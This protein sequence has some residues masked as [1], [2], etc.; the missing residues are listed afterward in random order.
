MPIV[1]C[2]SHPTA[3]G[4]ISSA[5]VTSADCRP[6]RIASTVSGASNVS[7]RTGQPHRNGAIRPQPSSAAAELVRCPPGG[8]ANTS[9][10]EWSARPAA[11]QRGAAS[12]RFSLSAAQRHGRSA[13]RLFIHR[14]IGHSGEDIVD[15]C[16]GIDV[17]VASTE[18]TVRATAALS[19]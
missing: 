14:M 9:N 3:N 17:A 8:G 19:S 15:P 16:L 2:L 4:F 1:L 7:R 13:A 12:W 10:G 6:S 5:S 11:K 18:L